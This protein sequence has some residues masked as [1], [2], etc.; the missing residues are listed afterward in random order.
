MSGSIQISEQHGFVRRLAHL[1][2]SWNGRRRTMADL[3]GCGSAEVERIARD[4][5]VSGAD[6]SVLAGK[7]PDAA[8]LLY[9]NVFVRLWRRWMTAQANQLLEA[10]RLGSDKVEYLTHGREMSNADHCRG[11]GRPTL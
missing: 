4:V 11:A 2:R 1:W 3:D 5:G 10:A 8:D 9:P 6:L 7:W